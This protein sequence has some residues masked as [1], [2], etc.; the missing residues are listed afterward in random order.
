MGLKQMLV[1]VIIGL[2]ADRLSI[3]TGDPLSMSL[4]EPRNTG[5]DQRDHKHVSE[6]S[7]ELRR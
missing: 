1:V 7:L 5:S 3:N 6:H 2:L 4:K